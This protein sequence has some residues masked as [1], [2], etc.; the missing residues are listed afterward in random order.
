MYLCSIGQLKD[1]VGSHELGLSIQQETPQLLMEGDT[2]DDQ[3]TSCDSSGQGQT[4][5]SPYEKEFTR[6]LIPSASNLSSE[7]TNITDQSANVKSINLPPTIPSQSTD[8]IVTPVDPVILANLCMGTSATSTPAGHVSSLAGHVSSPMGHVSSPVAVTSSSAINMDPLQVHVSSPLAST[9]YSSLPVDTVSYAL[10][11]L[12]AAS[13]SWI[14]SLPLS[15]FGKN[16]VSPLVL[17]LTS[18]STS[19]TSSTSTSASSTSASSTS[20]SSSTSMSTSTSSSKSIST[21]SSKSMSLS[22]V[23]HHDATS[24]MKV[25]SGKY[26]LVHDILYTWHTYNN[27]VVFYAENI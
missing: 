14:S 21:S 5:I 9:C 27:V 11:L 2:L 20:A 3:N 8:Y 26:I 1:L 18:T 22:T 7:G 12:T 24:S 10:A 17:P 4:V 13:D 19:T 6:R 25:P 23:S 16:E 15:L